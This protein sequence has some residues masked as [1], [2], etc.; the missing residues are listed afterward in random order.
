MSIGKK[1][2]RHHNSMKNNNI[3]KKEEFSLNRD[4][5]YKPRSDLHP[6]IFNYTNIF[7]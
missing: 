7:F 3:P 6:V 1:V 2:P 5:K 4:N